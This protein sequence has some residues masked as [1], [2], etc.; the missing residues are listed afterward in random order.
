MRK[1]TFFIVGCLLACSLYGES[2]AGYS[3]LPRDANGWTIFTPSVDTRIVYVST[4]GN[5]STGQVYSSASAE[6]G[7]DPFKPSGEIQPFATY[8][9]AYA[10]TRDGYPDWILFKRG[11]TFYTSINSTK[12]G[13][14]ETEP[15][16]IGAYGTS[17]ASPVIKHGAS[18]GLE[19]SRTSTSIKASTAYFAVS[20]LRF[21]AHTRDPENTNEFVSTAGGSNLFLMAYNSGN[22][23]S[24]GLIEGCEFSFGSN[25]DI[26][27]GTT[28]P[29]TYL[30]LRRNTFLSTYPY[31]GHT[32]GLWATKIDG[33]L[34]E[35]NIF[36]HN[37][38]LVKDGEGVG[39]G[40]IYNHNTYFADVK[41]TT[42]KNNI[43]MRGSN[44]N[45]KFTSPD[46]GTENVTIEGNLYIGGHIGIGI[47]TNYSWPD[48]F[49]NIAIKNNVM[50]NIGMDNITGQGIA[51]YIQI[52]GWSKGVVSGNLLMNQIGELYDGGFTLV[53]DIWDDA[54]NVDILNNILYKFDD[55]Q[56]TVLLSDSTTSTFSFSSNTIS[57]PNGNPNLVNTKTGDHSFSNNKW[58][59]FSGENIGWIFNGNNGSL[60]SFSSAVGDSSSTYGN[61]SFPDATRSI[62]TYMASL[63]ETATIDAF[64][65]KARAQDRYNWDHNI[66]AE[67]ANAWI[68]DGFGMGQRRLFRN[69]RLAAPV[70]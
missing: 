27:A 59:A 36:D 61:I 56:T 35:E 50:T 30:T 45:N 69:V 40:T 6:V 58:Y 1:Y 17:G 68:K 25:N 34:L 51:W 23:L 11:D 53:I 4:A 43:F 47:G 8:G 26:S 3:N 46:A 55:N 2:F 60:S 52:A 33:F 9:A 24:S 19:I 29:I 42:L 49:K 37:G 13:R 21:Y 38:W 67:A 62:E 64:I 5:D 10:Q 12:S 65:A 31:S 54:K 20:S 41:N 57:I 28:S 15:F 22:S 44:M 32:Q 70:E 18:N 66:T 14:S 16:F 63:G 48:R 7:T 39:A